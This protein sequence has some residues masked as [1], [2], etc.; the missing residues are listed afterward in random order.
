MPYVGGSLTTF[1]DEIAQ[2]VTK[3]AAEEM[4]GKGAKRVQELTKMNTPVRSGALR[5]SWRVEGPGP[6]AAGGHEGFRATVSTNVSY[7]PHVEH[8]TGLFGPK[9]AP[10]QILPRNP[11]GV[12]RFVGKDGRIVFARSVLHPGSPGNHML[13]IGMDVTD[14]EMR[15]GGL[16]TGVLEDWVRGVEGLAR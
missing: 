9:H 16:F 6:Y 15:D 10:Y 8:G 13:Q 1:F 11:G 12:L 7:G 14:G 5:N 3:H 4:C 2:A